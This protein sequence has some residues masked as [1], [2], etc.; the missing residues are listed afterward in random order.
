MTCSTIQMPRA[1]RK[2]RAWTKKLRNLQLVRTLH[3]E[4]RAWDGRAR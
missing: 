3:R 4:A 2:S 1:R